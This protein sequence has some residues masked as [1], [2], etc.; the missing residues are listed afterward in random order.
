MVPSSASEERD[1][2]PLVS[3]PITVTQFTP[4]ANSGSQA[5]LFTRDARWLAGI[6][7]VYA[8][9]VIATVFTLHPYFSQ[10]WDV[11]TFVNA[12]KSA[13]SPEWN[14][15]YAQSRADRYW[16]YAYPPLHAFVVAPF[17]ALA[18]L[19]PDWLLVRIPPLLFDIAL[20]IL[21]YEILARRTENKN[22]ARLG[23]LVWLLN[24]VTWYDTAVQGHFEAE[25]LFFIALAYF[26]F[27][28]KRSWIVPTLCLAVAFLFK[29]NA[30]LFAM[31]LWA[32][33]IFNPEQSVSRRALLFLG[34][35]I[36]FILPI[37][38]VSLPFLLFSNDY[39]YMNVQY[40][41]DVPLQTQSWLVALA[42]AF[43]AD[44]LF[45]RA[46]SPLTILAAVVISIFAAR[47]G[48]NVWLTAMLIALSF[49]LLSKKVVGYYYVMILPFA[50]VTLIPTKHFRLLSLIVVAIAFIS[51][52]P[53]FA[54]WAN[55]EHGWLYGA[56]GI[57]NSA[58]WLGIFV[59]LWRNHPLAVQSAQNARVL[60]F[61]SLALFFTGVLAAL[62]QPF[63][64]SATSP[65]R[66]P[67]LPSGY[68]LQ[69]F[70]LFG[71]FL[72]LVGGAIFLTQ[73]FTQSIARGER[74]PRAAYA[75]VVLLAPLYFLTFT[76]TKE[77]TAALEFA[78]KMLRV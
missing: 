40:V 32:L 31:P 45:L 29:Q 6:G 55:Q 46:S 23:M 33:L 44:N 66:A 17:V 56:L 51:L 34:S 65:I 1:L 10:T 78:L 53:Y 5:L 72:A 71:V 16:P 68:E 30:I 50:L 43:G 35:I 63:I 74:I 19:V 48:M 38:I 75:L 18:G 24:P 8:L 2:T 11:V 28:T 64:A 39:W 12:G 37:L 52:S 70:A 77:S 14:A 26:L 41:A 67:L 22:L 9:L 54:S 7:L 62:L 58:L 15:L 25:W 76:L 47:R 3:S 73:W 21:L 42:N 4:A 59:W 27:E 13:L 49:F 61:F 20:G 60:A 57:L 36:V 69:T